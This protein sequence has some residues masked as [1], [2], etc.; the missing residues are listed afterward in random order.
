MGQPAGEF[1]P[2]QLH[3]ALGVLQVLRRVA[4]GAVRSAEHLMRG[5][6]PPEVPRPL[7]E[8]EGPLQ[9]RDGLVDG[10]HRQVGGCLPLQRPGQEPLLP[11]PLRQR[12][13]LGPAVEGLLQPP[14]RPGEGVRARVG[15]SSL[16][17]PPLPFQGSPHPQV[18]RERVGGELGLL[19]ELRPGQQAQWESLLVCGRTAGKDQEAHQSTQRGLPPSPSSSG[20][21]AHAMLL[22]PRSLRRAMVPSR[23]GASP[24]SPPRAP[25][26]SSR[27][28]LHLRSRHAARIP[29]PFP[30]GCSA[31]SAGP[32]ERVLPPAPRAT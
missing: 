16:L 6:R 10:P 2:P 14:E 3:G 7:V 4:Q 18:G 24:L 11:G 23:S 19:G 12:D 5:P 32:C 25:G 1:V 27:P 30:T 13:G 28:P 9:D 8:R 26:T 29:T 22:Q 15:D 17:V 20:S 21:P 31:G